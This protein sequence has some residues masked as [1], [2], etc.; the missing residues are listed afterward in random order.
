MDKMQLAFA[1]V[2]EY[3]DTEKAWPPDFE[4]LHKPLKV[5]QVKDVD[6]KAVQWYECN[7]LL[8]ESNE[9]L[10]QLQRDA[11]LLTDCLKDEQMRT[12]M[13][14]RLGLEGR[15][16][17]QKEI[18]QRL[19]IS[20]SLVSNLIYRGI[21]W[22]RF[23]RDCDENQTWHDRITNR[24]EMENIIRRLRHIDWSKYDRKSLPLEK[25][26]P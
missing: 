5:E 16:L 7:N 21:H 2:G 22:M 4:P 3:L 20:R 10:Q 11:L 17:S 24:R 19:N 1:Q 12:V 15:C 18:A 6:P 9:D 13:R 14:L 23:H 8:A 25:K 26:R